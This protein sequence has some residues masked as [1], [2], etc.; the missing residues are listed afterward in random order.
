MKSIKEHIALAA[1]LMFERYL[2]DL[3]GGNIS[4]RVGDEIY[5]TPRYAGTKWHWKLCPE[6]IVSGPISTDDLLAN[7]SF[8]RE[9]KSHLHTY[10]NFPEAKAVIHAHPPHILP[11]V[12]VSKPIPPVLRSTTKFGSLEYIVDSEPYS[13]EQAESIVEHLRGKEELMKSSTA[14]VLMPRHGIFLVGQDLDVV[15]DTLERLN[16]NAYCVL[17]QRLLL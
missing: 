5:C 3:S 15:L 7:A 17:A 8:T 9:G 16:T 14:G 13:W 6:D 2:T 12:S 10:R 11:F 4:V 1:Q